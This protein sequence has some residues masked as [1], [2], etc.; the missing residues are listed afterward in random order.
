MTGKVLLV[1]GV[2]SLAMGYYAEMG[3]AGQSTLYNGGG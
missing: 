2:A 3:R 1:T